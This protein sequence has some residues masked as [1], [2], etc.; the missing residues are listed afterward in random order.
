MEELK[1]GI[2]QEKYIK[3]TSKK[4]NAFFPLFTE[5]YLE[6]FLK[7]TLN[8]TYFR[9]VF[10][11]KNLIWISAISKSAKLNKSTFSKFLFMSN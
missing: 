4:F 11:I 3:R 2:F 6:A 9:R 10:I 1:N 8:G 7:C 5:N